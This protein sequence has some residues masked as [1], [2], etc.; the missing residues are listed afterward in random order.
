MDLLYFS[1]AES[2]MLANTQNAHGH[3]LMRL[4]FLD[5]V[6]KRI[7]KITHELRLPHPSD[8][9]QQLYTL[10][11]PG[12]RFDAYTS[13]FHQDLFIDQFPNGTCAYQLKSFIDRMRQKVGSM[14]AYRTKFV[15]KDLRDRG[16]FFNTWGLQYFDF[17][18][19]TFKGLRTS[20]VLTASLQEGKRDLLN[21]MMRD[22]HKA[23][24]MLQEMGAHLIILRLFHQSYKR[25]LDKF[26]SKLTGKFSDQSIDELEG[27][28]LSDQLFVSY[29]KTM[30]SFSDAGQYFKY[31]FQ[32]D[33][34]HGNAGWLAEFIPIP[35]EL[36]IFSS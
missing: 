9:T 19:K 6:Y 14:E 27:L 10:V 1:A 11:S 8:K 21:W 25:Y 12:E 17:Q 3:E 18:P 35:I 4:G 34:E 20:N 2:Y 28:P 24:I 33:D 22:V 26:I 31:L 16:F 23:R 29:L 5:L 15:F 13:S 36:D 7:L 32:P 30:Q